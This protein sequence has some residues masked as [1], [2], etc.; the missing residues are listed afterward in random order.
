M[1]T[2]KRRRFRFTAMDP[3][4]SG[5]RLS[6]RGPQSV[7]I[8]IESPGAHRRLF[9]RIEGQKFIIALA[10]GICC[11]SGNFTSLQ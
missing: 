8:I 9:L 11:A 5:S 7:L 1:T 6:S 2:S 4:Y 10:V 3:L